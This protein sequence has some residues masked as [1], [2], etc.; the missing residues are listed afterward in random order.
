MTYAVLMPEPLHVVAAVIHNGDK[1]LACRRNAEKTA[2]GKWEFPGGKIESGES[3]PEALAR[4][5]AEELD[6]QSVSIG[7]LL[8]KSTHLGTSPAIELS[9][10]WVDAPQQPTQSS[11]HDLF[12][13]CTAKELSALDWAEADLVAVKKLQELGSRG[14]LDNGK[15]ALND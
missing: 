3:A 9:C 10:Y 6:L 12:R 2:G 4:E 15:E 5:L 7:R 8:S 11:D 1:I 13:W 14:D